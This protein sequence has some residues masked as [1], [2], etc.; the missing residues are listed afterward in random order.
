ML[1]AALIGNDAPHVKQRL[2]DESRETLRQTL[3]E[4]Q[5][6]MLILADA[7]ALRDASNGVQRK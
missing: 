7:R 1:D 2:Q 5:R 3:A 4:S 6:D